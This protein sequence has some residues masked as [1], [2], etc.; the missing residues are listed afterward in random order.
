MC[1]A[2]YTD[3][4]FDSETIP[5]MSIS[6]NITNKAKM[7]SQNYCGDE[8]PDDIKLLTGQNEKD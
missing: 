5:P 2:F 6:L 7:S 1:F 3:V 8:A 4:Y